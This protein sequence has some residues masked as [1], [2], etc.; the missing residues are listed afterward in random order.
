MATL[1]D[2][3]G[4]A[5]APET[6]N[7]NTPTIDTLPPHIQPA[8]E[9]PHDLYEAKALNFL[10]DNRNQF[11]IKAVM[12]FSALL[13]DGAVELTDGRRLTVEVK[14]RMNWEKA[15]QAEWQFRN[16]M[17]RTDV[18][19]FPVDGGLVI[20]EQFSG[21]WDKQ[22]A[23]RRLENG[24]STWYR[25]HAEVDALR[26]DLLQFRDGKIHG[27]PRESHDQSD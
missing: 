1:S 19:P 25:S 15:C 24:W 7:R 27:Y 6:K 21:D 9:K 3:I 26:L 12:R 16:F 2:L 8:T 11:G 5:S 22:A 17:R 23:C 10:W 4:R 14:F 18:R 13:V 20:F